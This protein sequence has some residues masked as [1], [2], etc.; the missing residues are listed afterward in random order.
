MAVLVAAVA[1]VL[2]YRWS[3][4]HGPDEL[5]TSPT[6]DAS[7]E[8]AGLEP[9]LEQVEDEEGRAFDTIPVDT[10]GIPLHSR[11]IGVV[12]LVLIVV[13]VAL[14]AVFAVRQTAHVVNEQIR[15]YLSS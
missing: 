7:A 14:L 11:L 4:G 10:G 1:G 6:P 3:L 12:G 13:L 9:P 2:V 5:P 8:W 15:N